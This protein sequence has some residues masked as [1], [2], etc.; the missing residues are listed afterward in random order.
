M[1]RKLFIIGIGML[2]Q[3]ILIIAVPNESQAGRKDRF[4]NWGICPPGT[5][6]LDGTD[7][8]MDT[9]KCKPQ[10]CRRNGPARPSDNSGTT[11]QNKPQ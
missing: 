9:R 8:A 5:C 6:A 10:H 4:P 3:A 2:I 11:E 1:K 7:K